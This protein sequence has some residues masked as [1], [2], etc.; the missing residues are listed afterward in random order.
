MSSWRHRGPDNGARLQ[1]G[2]ASMRLGSF[3]AALAGVALSTVAALAQPQTIKPAIVY[4]KGGKFDKSFNEAAF[5]GAEP[6]LVYC[7]IFALSFLR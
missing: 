5:T 1:Q 2:I 6:D 7:E 3:A 4:D